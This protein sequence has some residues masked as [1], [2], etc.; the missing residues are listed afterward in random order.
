M[1]KFLVFAVQA[2]AIGLLFSCAS[3]DVSSPE[4][5]LA[6]A[7]SSSDGSP[8][9]ATSSSS[10]AP[11][12]SG[13]LVPSSSSS[14]PSGTVLCEYSGICSPV[15]SE[16]C[17]LLG[18]ALVQSCPE[19]SS[20]SLIALSSSSVA[21]ISSS[22]VPSSSSSS[23]ELYSSSALPS[24]SSE[25]ESSSSVVP[26]SSSVEPSSS[27]ALPSSDSEVSSSSSGGSEPSSSS[28]GADYRI[29]CTGSIEDC[30][31]IG[32]GEVN[33]KVGECVE[34]AVLNH[35]Y[36][37][38]YFP[39]VG[40]RCHAHV[41]SGYYSPSYTLALNGVLQATVTGYS[42]IDVPLG[43]IK[44]GDNELGTLCLKSIYEVTEVRCEFGIF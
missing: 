2:M 10:S 20:S 6:L 26:S 1:N 34:I 42:G 29:E 14:L 31:R 25:A 32:N 43:R 44:L 37:E 15:S 12:S 28:R 22:S 11:I 23:V 18:G 36:N 7:G 40:M 41:F 9:T 35:N 39:N 8:G 24:S 38:Q 16:V 19:S 5:D 17:A 21:I 30:R 4:D 33:L 3:V 13:S 27:S